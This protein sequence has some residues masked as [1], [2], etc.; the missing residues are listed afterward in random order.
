VTLRAQQRP[1]S[2]R[3]AR[4]SAVA[5][6]RVA[7]DAI[8]VTATRTSSAVRDLPAKATVLSAEALRSTPAATIPGL[9]LQLPGFTLGN[10]G[11]P[12]TQRPERS[13][14]SF[15]G[16]GGTSAS[17]ALVLLDGIPVNDPF[18]SFVRW[19]RIPLPLVERVE[20][21]HGGGAMAWGSRSLG[22]VINMITAPP[23]RPRLEATVEGGG[24]ATYRVA[25]A[26]SGTVGKV[27]IMV[28]GDL[29]DTDG[30]M[31]LRPDQIGVVDQPRG[32]QT[33]VGYAKLSYQAS[34]TLRAT[35]AV[36]SLDDRNRGETALSAR[37]AT[38]SELRG[39]LEWSAPTGGVVSLIGYGQ[40]RSAVFVLP[41]VSADR[42]TETPRRETRL[43]S[44]AIGGTLQWTQTLATRHA[45]TAGVDVSAVDGSYSDRH[46]Y[47]ADAPTRER[48]S[49]G[50]QHTIGAFVQDGVR[51]GPRTR[52]TAGLRVDRIRNTDGRRGEILLSSGAALSDSSYDDASETAVTYNLGVQQRFAPG[53]LVRAAGYRAFR[54]ATLFELNTPLYL[55]NVGATVVEA[56]PNLL[57][58]TLVGG[59][60]G[61]DFELDQRVL[62]RVTGFW[63]EVRNPIV[64]FTVGT[65]TGASQVIAPCGR[66]A[67]NAVCRQRRNV[68]TLQSRGAEV[69]L[70]WRPSSAWVLGS[71]YSHNPTEII[72][73]G[74][75]VDGKSPRGA[76]RNALTGT[77]AWS[78]PRLAAIHLEARWVDG[79]FDDDRNTIRLD[80]F[81]VLGMSVSR[82][83]TA[84]LTAYVRVE[85]LLDEVYEVTRGS[86]GL[87]EVGGPRWIMAG[88]RGRW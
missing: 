10:F 36:N 54:N 37:S 40:Q 69:E 85:N 28:A 45:V 72:S 44:D 13:S 21:V 76:V 27:G 31:L 30:F 51:L 55:G 84:Q 77:V 49:G 50:T 58:E 5:A 14:G 20:V 12:V 68:G 47:V 4:D 9:L 83:V 70:Q 81:T 8:T 46:S 38:T 79:R 1:D 18:N 24:L 16:L 43:P 39:G 32:V 65:S 6:V 67:T 62:A 75:P 73:P 41:A 88:V 34:P 33:R 29:M 17:R 26:P 25:A 35:F 22:G 66:L 11:H 48:Q 60:I 63:N 52:L 87:A 74:E 3:A 19:S 78:A 80:P 86:S 82:P 61:A 71:S 42:T 23:G 53:I 64:E 2:A 57:S 7:L 59:E 15:R 56:N